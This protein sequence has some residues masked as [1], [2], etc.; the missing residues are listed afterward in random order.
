MT[1]QLAGGFTQLMMFD[2]TQISRLCAFNPNS[3]SA[4]KI[5]PLPSSFK[6]PSSFPAGLQNAASAYQEY[7]SE[8]TQSPFEKS[9]P[10]PFGLHNMVKSYQARFEGSLDPVL[11]MPLKGAQEGLV[12]IITSQDCII[13]WPGSVPKCSGTQLVGTITTTI[14]PYQEGDSIC[15]LEASTKVINNSNSMETNADD[16]TTHTREVFMI[17]HPRS[18]LPPRSTQHQIIR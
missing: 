2:P 9:G 3:G 1:D 7:N 8:Y 4:S 16:R 10:F 6:K 12:L 15:D 17:R 14:L 18:P 5:E 11:K 13:H